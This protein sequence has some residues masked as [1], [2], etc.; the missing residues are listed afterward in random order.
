MESTTREI[1]NIQK[2]DEILRLPD[3]LEQRVEQRRKDAFVGSYEHI[4]GRFHRLPI[5]SGWTTYSK[6]L[7]GCGAIIAVKYKLPMISTDVVPDDLVDFAL[8]HESVESALDLTASDKDHPIAFG[9]SK[10]LGI[11]KSINTS[12]VKWNH[13]F[14]TVRQLRLAQKHNKLDEMMKFADAIESKPE[15]SVSGYGNKELRQAVYQLL[16]SAV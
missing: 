5:V 15:N 16:N 11:T 13:V 6:G 7:K 12:N 4:K 2:I 9:K 8:E 10:E 3:D 14:A 1:M